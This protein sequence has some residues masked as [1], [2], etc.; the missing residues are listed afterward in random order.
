MFK[1]KWADVH[2]YIHIYICS[3]RTSVCGT[4]GTQMNQ[5][6]ETRWDVR[7]CFIFVSSCGGERCRQHEVQVGVT[8]NTVWSRLEI[9]LWSN[10][11]I[12]KWRLRGPEYFFWMNTWFGSVALGSQLFQFFAPC[13][14]LIGSWHVGS[15][16]GHRR[17]VTAG[18]R[19]G[20]GGD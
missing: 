10:L 9:W 6:A 3:V 4:H 2:V 16:G 1:S 15:S 14:F 8:V 13:F 19:K 18:H 11:E 7:S 12:R 5:Q 17:A 20:P